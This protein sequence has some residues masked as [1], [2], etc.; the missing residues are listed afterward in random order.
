MDQLLLSLGLL[1]ERERERVGVSVIGAYHS[2]SGFDQM[3]Y[4]GCSDQ[5]LKQG[6]RR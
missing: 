5:I 3:G 4:F 6:R 2:V 1:R